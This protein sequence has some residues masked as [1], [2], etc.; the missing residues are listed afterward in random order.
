MGRQP[1]QHRKSTIVD[2]E[3]VPQLTAR[4]L[5]AISKTVTSHRPADLIESA[6]GVGKV[7]LTAVSRRGDALGQWR[8]ELRGSDML[9]Q[10]IIGETKYAEILPRELPY[11]FD[12]ALAGLEQW[13]KA[14]NAEELKWAIRDTPTL[15]HLMPEHIMEPADYRPL[16]GTPSW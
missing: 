1:L 7:N 11:R 2:T 12:R 8:L 5:A 14:A 9:L 13:V 4:Q 10:V 16:G 3:N 6:V 15:G